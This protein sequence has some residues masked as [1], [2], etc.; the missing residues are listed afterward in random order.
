MGFASRS[1]SMIRYRV[2]GEMEGS[3]WDAVDEGIKQGAFKEVESSGDT[4][5]LGWVSL[6]DFTDTEFRGTS[7]LRGNYVAFSLRIDTVRVPPRIL[8]IHVK[9]E[10]RKLL[11]ETGQKR[12][13]SGQRR[14]LKDRLKDALKKRVFPSIQVFDVIWDTSKGILYLGTLGIKVRERLEDHFKKSFGLRLIPLIPYLR[15]EELLSDKSEQKALE[16]LKSC[17]FAP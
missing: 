16:E 8:E 7:Y 11:E 12:L 3:F 2:R 17:S 9:Q 5:G 15:A 4:V 6:E 13:S 1:V 10:T 14:D